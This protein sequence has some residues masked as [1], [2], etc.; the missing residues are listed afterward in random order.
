MTPEEIQKM[1]DEHQAKVDKFNILYDQME[2]SW[3]KV[4]HSVSAI[5][6]AMAEAADDAKDQSFKIDIESAHERIHK[7]ENSDSTSFGEILLEIFLSAFLKIGGKFIGAKMVKRFFKSTQAQA[8]IIQIN[9]NTLSPSKNGFLEGIAALELPKD[10]ALT[11]FTKD[12]LSEASGKIGTK[13]IDLVSAIGNS[14]FEVEDKLPSNPNKKG[15]PIATLSALKNQRVD[16]AP[17]P[18]AISLKKTARDLKNRSDSVLKE[19]KLRSKAARSIVLSDKE[20]T[21]KEKYEYC[22][23]RTFTEEGIKELTIKPSTIEY[24]ILKEKFESSLFGVICAIEYLSEKTKFEVISKQDA[25]REINEQ[26]KE[27]HPYNLFST[28][29]L[30]SRFLSVSSKYREVMGFVM[31]TTKY[32]SLNDKGRTNVVLNKLYKEVPFLEGTSIP[33]HNYNQPGDV[34]LPPIVEKG[35]T[36]H[37]VLALTKTAKDRIKK[38]LEASKYYSGPYFQEIRTKENLIDDSLHDLKE[39]D[40]RILVAIDLLLNQYIEAMKAGKIE[41]KQLIANA[42]QKYNLDWTNLDGNEEGSN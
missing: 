40:P 37:A 41:V 2:V 14:L 22:L 7:I 6:L 1:I 11:K 16:I 18:V 42:K 8:G 20:R 27:T 36:I 9:M 3:E 4:F 31:K 25:K 21:W 38:E 32:L 15:N 34:T 19:M 23:K 26:I 29:A 5:Y 17:D 30:A 13:S 28:I 24:N 12:V 35:Q 39:K 10:S 33:I